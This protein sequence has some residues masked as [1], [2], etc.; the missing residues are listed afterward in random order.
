MTEAWRGTWW[1]PFMFE[2]QRFLQETDDLG[3]IPEAE[4]SFLSVHG[5]LPGEPHD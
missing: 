1:E 3:D 2:E 4:A 5:Y